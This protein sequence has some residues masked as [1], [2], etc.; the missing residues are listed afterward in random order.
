MWGGGFNEPFIDDSLPQPKVLNSTWGQ[1]LNKKQTFEDPG[2][3]SGIPADRVMVSARK[4]SGGMWLT[5]LEKLCFPLSLNDFL[6]QNKVPVTKH[7]RN[8]EGG[9]MEGSICWKLEFH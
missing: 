3:P 7:G 9:G 4:G 2:Q 8:T 6:F 1:S 5:Q